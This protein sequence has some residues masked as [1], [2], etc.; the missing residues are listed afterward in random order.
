MRQVLQKEV[1]DDDLYSEFAD[2]S[3]LGIILRHLR[4]GRLLDRNRA[5][6]VLA[7]R[8]KTPIRTICAFLVSVREQIESLESV[9]ST[10]LNSLNLLPFCAP[11]IVLGAL[12]VDPGE[13]RSL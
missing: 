12:D 2:V 8:R 5:M 11:C 13:P 1:G 3:D 4:N 6:V 10:P 7:S 9:S